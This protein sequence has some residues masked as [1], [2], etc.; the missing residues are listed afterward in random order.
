MAYYFVEFY[1]IKYEWSKISPNRY[2]V[3]GPV[4]FIK[5]K[6][7]SISIGSEFLKKSQT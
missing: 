5:Q 7:K 1:S 2:S 3:F 6:I 4:D